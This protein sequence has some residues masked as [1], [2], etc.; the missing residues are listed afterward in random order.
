MPLSLLLFIIGFGLI[1]G[2]LVFILLMSVNALIKESNE[3]WDIKMQIEKKK[4]LDWVETE[5]IKLEERYPKL[6]GNNE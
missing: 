5:K 4:M 3:L 1:G 2:F 6:E